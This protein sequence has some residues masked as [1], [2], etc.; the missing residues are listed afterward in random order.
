MNQ[1][2]FYRDSSMNLHIIF[3]VCCLA[4][5]GLSIYLTTHFYE[6]KYPEGLGQASLCDISSFFNCDVA[7]HSPA[8]NLMG[9]PISVFGV[10]IGVFLLFGYLFPDERT[11]GTNHT[12]LLVNGLGSAI[13]L[14]YSLV[15]LGGLCPFCTL[16]YIASWIALFV[17]RKNSN[18]ITIGP[19]QVAIY[20]FI[21][22]GISIFFYNHTSGKE[23]NYTAI[24]KS[25][26]GQ[27]VKLRDL[28]VPSIE[29]EYRLVSATE[30]FTDAPIQITKYSDY[31]CPSCKAL[32]KVLH[33]VAK[34]YPGKIN[35]Q[36]F[37]YPLD[38]NCNPKMTRDMHRNACRAAYFTACLPKK[39][40][41]VEE[42]VFE[43]Q[44]NLSTE[45]IN[46]WAEQ[47]GVT[48]CMNSEETK[49]KVLAYI[50]TGDQFNVKSTPTFLVNGKKIEG[51]LPVLQLKAI[52]DHL[53]KIP[54]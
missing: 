30:K 27:Y 31:E 32:S 11:E 5:I 28:G 24:A 39:F 21:T 41:E 12:I 52:I 7:T 25:V 15:F 14:V 20:G 54:N 34:A 23:N 17:F 49:Q 42:L 10:L 26:V 48:D 2:S 50:N 45:Q 18:I 29:S 35:I 3:V 8:S 37:F 40:A 53:L 13:L 46:K 6:V 9:V 4:M 1:K 33:R 51:A 43:N 19:P 38:R 44:G 22:V 36:Y 16:Y 47:Y